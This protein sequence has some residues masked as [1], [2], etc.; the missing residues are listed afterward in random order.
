MQ[1][2]RV[3]VCVLSIILPASVQDQL[4]NNWSGSFL[5]CASSFFFINSFVD[6]FGPKRLPNE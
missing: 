2:S 3:S 6:H 1:R 4:D 5:M